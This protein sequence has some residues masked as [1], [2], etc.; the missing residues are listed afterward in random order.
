MPPEGRIFLE[1]I[2]SSTYVIPGISPAYATG[3]LTGRLNSELEVLVEDD[4]AKLILETC[5]TSELR[6]R[7]KILPNWIRS[8]GHASTSCQI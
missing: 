4:S 5:L 7:I 1:H 3:K 8:G 2:G 6:S